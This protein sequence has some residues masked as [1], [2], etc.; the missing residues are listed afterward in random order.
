M[1]D[2]NQNQPDPPLLSE[3][4]DSPLSRRFFLRRA[5]VAGA[6]VAAAGC[7]PPGIE[8]RTA[9]DGQEVGRGMINSNSRA[10]TALDIAH[11][12]GHTDATVD[13]STV[14]YHRYDPTLPP[15]SDSRTLRLHWRSTEVP[16]RISRNKVV[17]AW[18][19]EGD[20]PGPIVH[21]RQGDTV[22]FTLT[23]E[24]VMPHS[25]DF[26]A[27][28]LNPAV[29]FRSV[30][31]GESVTF[32][33]QPRYA[34]AFLYH[35]GTGPVLMHIGAGMYGAIIVDPP[36]PLPAAKEFVLVQSEYYISDGPGGI[37]TIDYG[38]MME[39]VPDYVLFN[40]RP[41]QYILEPIRV[42]VGDRVRFY[43]VSA[44]PTYPCNFHLVGE[45]FDTVY[46]G[47]PPGSAINGVQTFAVPPGGGM[48]FEFIA[49]VPGEF[50]FVN[51]GFG[52]GQKGGIGFLVVE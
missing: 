32:T 6:A 3:I 24:G 17:A 51:H 12:P 22:E 46:L 23:N 48:I 13:A 33:F 4:I 36:D 39:T 16:V 18:T 21:V 15:L 45:Q 5:G 44:G 30:A 1:T 47:A 2:P 43:V 37:S 19:F 26:H 49:D 42:S 40:G 20:V 52:H 38:K 50:P 34:G 28:Q 14:E 8:E 41:D 35:C 29:A 31:Q 10:D 11:T 27:S 9:A 25:M 7:R